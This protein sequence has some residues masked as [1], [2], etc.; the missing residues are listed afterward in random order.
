MRL[1][2]GFENYEEQ[3]ACVIVVGHCVLSTHLFVPYLDGKYLYDDFNATRGWWRTPVL[4]LLPPSK[5]ILQI[6]VLSCQNDARLC[7]VLTSK[8]RTQMMRWIGNMNKKSSNK[9]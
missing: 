9:Q 5:A 8:K 4:K 3:E 7:V 1:L 6:P 2:C